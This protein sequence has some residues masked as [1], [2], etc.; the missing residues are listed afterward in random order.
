MSVGNSRAACTREDLKR[1]RSEEGNCN[2]VPKRRK[3]NAEGQREYRETYK[4]I[5]AEFMHNYRKRKAKEIDLFQ[6]KSQ[7]HYVFNV[8]PGNQG[9]RF[10]YCTVYFLVISRRIRRVSSE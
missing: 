2:N 10:S 4:N 8:N 5:S 6:Y 3:L 9:S 1:K 7:F